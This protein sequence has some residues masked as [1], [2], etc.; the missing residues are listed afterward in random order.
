[1]GAMGIAPGTLDSTAERES[2]RCMSRKRDF[3]P[4]LADRKYDTIS[5]V[6]C[7]LSTELRR[8]GDA[9]GEA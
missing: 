9:N 2:A 4:A 1:M 5:R 7:D 3:S 6:D 8:W